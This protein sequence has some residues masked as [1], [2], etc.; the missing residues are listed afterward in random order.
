[1][2]MRLRHLTIAGAVI[3]S[4]LALTLVATGGASG[5]SLPNTSVIPGACALDLRADHSHCNLNLIANLK[6]EPKAAAGPT[7]GYGPAD[8]RSAYALPSSGGSGQ[9][10]AIVDSYGDTT[11]EAAMGTYRSNY[12]LPACTTANGCFKK[13]NQ[14]GTQGSYPSN[15]QGWSL[16]TQLDL[17]MAS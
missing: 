2:Y 14:T 10:I 15:D 16:E 3:A 8:L 6:G 5:A 9:T 17:Q 7:P 1:M 12:G 13:V 4:S 11:A